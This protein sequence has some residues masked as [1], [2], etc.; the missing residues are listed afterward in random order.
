[1]YELFGFELS[2]F[3]GLFYVFCLAVLVYRYCTVGHK[4]PLFSRPEKKPDTAEKVETEEACE[5]EHY[6]RKYPGYSQSDVNDYRS[7]EF[8]YYEQQNN[9]RH[10]H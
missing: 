7:N 1:M 5:T 6:Y 8:F 3:K 9:D 2:D 10:H 4:Y